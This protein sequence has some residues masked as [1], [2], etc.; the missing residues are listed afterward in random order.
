MSRLAAVT[1]ATGFL[2]RH[3][4]RELQAQGWSV[5]ALSRREP[6]PWDGP[7]PQVVRGDLE[8]SDALARLCDGADAV[9][10][11][12]G[13]VTA[14]RASDFMA[15]NADGARAVAKATHEGAPD[16]SYAL[17][18]SLAAREPQ[19]S[20]YAASKRAGERATRE[21]LG[22]RATIVRP[23]LIYGPGDLHTLPL[24]KAAARA[25]ALPWFNRGGRVAFI[26]VAD[27]AAQIAALLDARAGRIVA[28]HDRRPEGYAWREVLEAAAAAVGATPRLAPTPDAFVRA[29][30]RL[31][32][33]AAGLGAEPFL[34]SGK[35]R[36]AL[37]GDW[38]VHPVERDADA[39]APRFDLATG[40]AD[41]VA[42]G[43]AAGHLPP[44]SKDARPR[45]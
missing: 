35:A 5:R 12:A 14:R 20:P 45:S 29:A 23:P 2:G 8:D 43:R 18:S 7:A 30:G 16:A 10:H 19:L 4:V 32:D 40:F 37:H 24:F 11:V 34:T 41:T 13:R 3:L 44:S 1:G 15:A 22:A 38:S 36:E 42:W 17:V 21:I 6:P 27:A 31:G 9:I 28:P 39:P 33:V 25:P 26:H